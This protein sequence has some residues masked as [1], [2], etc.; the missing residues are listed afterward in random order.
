V[1]A[2]SRRSAAEVLTFAGLAAADAAA[3]TYL[4]IAVLLACA[5]RHHTVRKARW[6]PAAELFMQTE[7]AQ[8]PLPGLHSP[9]RSCLGR[10]LADSTAQ[11]QPGH[12]RGWPVE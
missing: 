9:K 8:E 12:V 4:N 6:S 3:Q 2:L 5:H 7:P 11:V 10:S 1:C